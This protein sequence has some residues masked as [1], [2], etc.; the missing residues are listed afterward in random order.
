MFVS[1]SER[2]GEAMRR[3]PSNKNMEGVSDGNDKNCQAKCGYFVPYKQR[4][5][6][7]TSSTQAI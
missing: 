7:P 1:E 6:R 5:M 3:H 2:A 4:D